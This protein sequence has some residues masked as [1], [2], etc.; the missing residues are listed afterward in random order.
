M[1]KNKSQSTNELRLDRSHK[2]TSISRRTLL[3]GVGVSLA[4]PALQIMRPEVA[5]ASEAGKAPVRLAWIFFPNGTNAASWLPSGSGKDWELSPSLAPLANQRDDFNVLRGLAQVNAQSLGD[6]PGD[7]ARSAA[8]FLTG[9]HPYKTDGSKIKN[10][11]S[12]DQIAADGYGQATRLA[13]LELGTEAGRDAGSCDSGYS[14]AYS[15]NISWRGESLPTGKEIKPQIAFRRLFGSEGLKQLSEEEK[16]MQR[17]ILDFVVDQRNHLNRISGVEDQRKLDEYFTS[18]REIETRMSRFQAPV[19]L[20]AGT[21]EPSEKPADATEHI[22]LMYDLMVLAFQTDTTRIASFMLGNEGS[23]R[24]FPMIDVKDGHHALS[25]HENNKSKI[26][27]IAKI[28]TYYT[29]QFAYFLS[30]LRGVKD[31][32]GSTLLDN[33][34]IVYGGCI[35]DGNRHDH[36]DL[37]VLLAGK[38]GRNLETGRLLEYA[39]FTPMNNLYSTMLEYIGMDDIVFGDGTGRLKLS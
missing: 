27:D 10:G 19:E 29:E 30:K 15:N 25:H 7:H 12:V 16:K 22:R 35:S 21:A 4:L 34:L 31:S 17:S 14:C 20:P 26:A 11:R 39:K 18:I 33:S 8:A 32:D 38:G 5:L 6:G 28:D 1:S 2:C 24:T 23:N 13:S 9:A 37:P 36:H 3:R